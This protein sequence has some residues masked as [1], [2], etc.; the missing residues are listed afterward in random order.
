MI[1]IQYSAEASE[2]VW[3]WRGQPPDAWGHVGVEALT[4][5]VNDCAND[6]LLT[7]TMP[8]FPW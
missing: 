8:S 3:S 6:D 7:P 4:G 1:Q 5:A 2:A